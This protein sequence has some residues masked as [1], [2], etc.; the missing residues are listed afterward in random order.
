MSWQIFFYQLDQLDLIGAAKIKEWRHL[1][2]PYQTTAEL[3]LEPN[4]ADRELSVNNC[5]I[6]KR[7]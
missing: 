5:P 7:I 4:Y 1:S 3:H 6:P 2:H